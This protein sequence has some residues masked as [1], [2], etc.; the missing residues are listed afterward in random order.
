MLTVESVSRNNRNLQNANHIIFYAPL[1]ARSQYDYESGMAQAIGR[2]R[3]YGQQKHVHIY[4]LLTLKTIEVNI[5]EQRRSEY[6]VKRN[7][8]HLPVSRS[9]VRVSDE[10]GWRGF[11]LHGTNGETSEESFDDI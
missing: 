9:E 3:R 4:H 8:Q 11:S 7:G 1:V 5:F 10:F 2:C 6:I